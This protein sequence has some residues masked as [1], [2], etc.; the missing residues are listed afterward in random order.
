M[1]PYNRSDLNA[2][3]LSLTRRILKRAQQLRN[4]SNQTLR[5][6]GLS[7]QYK[8][9]TGSRLS[10]LI[11]ESFA[12]VCESARRSI[13]LMPYQVQLFAGI[14]IA[15]GHIAEMKTGE[16]KTLAATLPVFLHALCGRGAH[17]VTVNDYLARRDFELMGPIYERLGLSV[18]V[19]LGGDTPEQRAA[20]YRSD[21]TFGT[22]KEFGF[23][24]LRD[25][26]RVANS[27]L[28]PS[29]QTDTVM[30]GL[31]FALVDEVDSVLIDEA[32]TPLIIGVSNRQEELKR[33][34]CFQ[35]AAQHAGPFEAVVDFTYEHRRKKVALTDAGTEKVRRLPQNEST[36]KLPIRK[37]YEFIENAIKVRR[38]FQLDQHYVVKD[39]KIAIVD[40]F[41]GRI[42]DGRQWQRGIHQSVEA[43]EHLDITPATGQGATITLQSFFRRYQ[44]FGGMS[45]TV[46]T[47]R[48]EFK[49]VYKKKL[50]RVP[51]HRPIRRTQMPTMIFSD[52]ESKLVA[53]VE[54]IKSISAQGRAVLAGTR[55]VEKSERLSKALTDAKIDHDVLNANQDSR[56]A[57]IIAQAGHAGRVTVATNMAGRGTDIVLDT[58][59]RNAGGLHVILTELHESRRIDWQLIGRGSRQGDPGSFRIFVAMDDELLL[60]G[61]G[62]KRADTLKLRYPAK[63]FRNQQLPER[64]LRNLVSAQL[65]LE[66]RHLVDRMILLRQDNDRQQRHFEMGLDPYCDVVQT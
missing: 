51:T 30:R 28:Q 12:L 44:F 22:A 52:F 6:Q 45:G 7:M 15:N 36:K 23:D 46:M 9:T 17:V 18:G 20:A 60:Q 10:Q 21:V 57:A 13:G 25:R 39:G 59:V 19:V 47:S 58:A 33:K 37:L 42:A 1:S 53:V 55:S 49:R 32:R 62:P 38:D 16:G 24:F 29:S 40:E 54:E 34:A 27:N 11:P 43:K 66:R 65:K 5:Q 35:W 4:W 50:V 2:Y 26:L 3:Q 31:H 8:A 48:S 41:T 63:R 64:L 61:L 14:Q 56:E